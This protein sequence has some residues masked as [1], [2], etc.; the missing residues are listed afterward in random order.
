LGLLVFP[1]QVFTLD[2]ILK[3]LLLSIILMVIARPIAVYLSTL[4]LGYSFK[5]KIFLSWSGLQGAVPIV[6]ATFPLAAGLANGQLFFNVI[7]F[8]VLLSA[9]VQGSNISNFAE[10]LNLTGPVKTEPMHSLELVSIGKANAEMIEYD[11]KGDL[12][13][14]GNTLADIDFPDDVLIN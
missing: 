2:I 12:A 14:I 13:I 11:I 1:K 4:K 6:L 8:I 10:K 7:F 5:E 3:G 9:L